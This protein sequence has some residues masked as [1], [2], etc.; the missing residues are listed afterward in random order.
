MLALTAGRLIYADEVHY[1]HSALIPRPFGNYCTRSAR[2]Y[3]G[4]NGVSGVV[5]KPSEIENNTTFYSKNKVKT[6]ISL[7]F[8][9]PLSHLLNCGKKQ[10]KRG[11]AFFQG[12]S[13]PIPAG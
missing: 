10:R 2:I 8:Q 3:E 7:L 5:E 12:N 13:N 6:S 11:Q 4:T 1:Y 9:R